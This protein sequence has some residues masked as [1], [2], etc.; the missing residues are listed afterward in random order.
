MSAKHT[1]GPWIAHQVL[2]GYGVP[3]TPVVGKTLL[4]K[5]YSEAFGDYAQSEANARLIAAAPDLLEE[6]L[7]CRAELGMLINDL[8]ANATLPDGSFASDEDEVACQFD[9]SRLARI[10]ALIAKATGSAK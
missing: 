4:A 7:I 3:F 6:L 8:R 10:D 2:L 5:V 1:P 9:E